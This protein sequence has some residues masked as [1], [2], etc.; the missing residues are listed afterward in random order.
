MAQIKLLDLTDDANAL[1]KDIL[2]SGVLPATRT[3]TP[4]TSHSPRFTKWIYF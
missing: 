4:H 1:T 2:S 3:A